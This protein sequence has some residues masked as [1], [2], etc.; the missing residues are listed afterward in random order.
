ITSLQQFT[1][2]WSTKQ[3]MHVQYILSWSHSRDLFLEL[4]TGVDYNYVVKD[5][6][7]LL[8]AVFMNEEHVFTP[9]FKYNPTEHYFLEQ[10]MAIFQKMQLMIDNEKMFR[11]QWYVDGYGR[12]ADRRYQTIN[13]LVFSEIIQLLINRDLTFNLEGAEYNNVQIAKDKDPF[14]FELVENDPTNYV[15]K[16]PELQSGL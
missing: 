14:Q 4:K 9:R 15:L 6:S 11:R 12:S 7:E 3:P 2:E 16:F 5:I 13:P 1:E 10:D 8:H